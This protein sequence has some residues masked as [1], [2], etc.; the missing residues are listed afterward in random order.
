[1]IDSLTRA[2]ALGIPN[3]NEAAKIIIALETIIAHARQH[4]ADWQSGIDDGTYGKDTQKK[5]DALNSALEL[6]DPE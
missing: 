2:I 6:I 5:C 1:M 4:H 3:E